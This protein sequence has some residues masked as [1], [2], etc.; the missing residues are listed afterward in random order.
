MHGDGF[1]QELH[2]RAYHPEMI[3]NECVECNEDRTATRQGSIYINS[4]NRGRRFNS[5]Q[6]ERIRKTEP[7]ACFM[8]LMEWFQ[9]HSHR[10]V[11]D[12]HGKG[13][14]STRKATIEQGIKIFTAE[15]SSIQHS[16]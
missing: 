15:F 2:E 9:K 10:I 5:L 1:L 4:G 16:H 12:M 8:H 11:R 14:R 7:R 13:I 6:G 3:E